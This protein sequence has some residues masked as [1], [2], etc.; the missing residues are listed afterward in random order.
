MSSIYFGQLYSLG[1]MGR[2]ICMEEISVIEKR[3]RENEE[4]LY[5]EFL[6]AAPEDIRE[7][8]EEWLILES[9]I[10]YGKY[11]GTIT[12][13]D[14]CCSSSLA[15]AQ[16]K[17]EALKQAWEGNINYSFSHD[18]DEIEPDSSKLTIEVLRVSLL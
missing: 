10:K 2:L 8:L 6:K 3:M 18:P 12:F 15:D 9:L 17:L 11:Q 1:C 4:R 14:D 7:F 13:D 16:A 5:I